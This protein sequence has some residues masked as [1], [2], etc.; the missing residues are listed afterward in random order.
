MEQMVKAY[1]GIYPDEWHLILLD[2]EIR[3]DH[4]ISVCRPDLAIARG[5]MVIVKGNG[6]GDTSS[7]PERD[8][9]HFT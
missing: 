6:H 9:L 3:A 5:V 7:T 8:W 2:F 4:L 1:I